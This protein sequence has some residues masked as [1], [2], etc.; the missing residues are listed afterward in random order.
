MKL[1][2]LSIFWIFL[3]RNILRNHNTNFFFILSIFR[4]PLIFLHLQ[5]FSLFCIFFKLTIFGY[6]NLFIT[7]SLL[8]IFILLFYLELKSYNY[9]LSRAH[10]QVK[11]FCIVCYLY[12]IPSFKFFK[13][14]I[15]DFIHKHKAKNLK[16]SNYCVAK[17]MGHCANQE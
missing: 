12:L 1:L 14:L 4:K 7:L 8:S 10:N 3:L 2:L 15:F 6:S 13:L 9:F 16:V 5:L 17:N 11:S